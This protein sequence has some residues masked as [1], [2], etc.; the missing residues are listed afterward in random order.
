MLTTTNKIPIMGSNPFRWAKYSEMLSSIWLIFCDILAP[1]SSVGV[2]C[3]YGYTKS[4]LRLQPEVHEPEVL[5][6]TQ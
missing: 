5:E 6:P 1:L 2:V 4:R 3:G